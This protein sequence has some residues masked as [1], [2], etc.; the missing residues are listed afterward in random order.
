MARFRLHDVSCQCRDDLN[1]AYENRC[2]AAC[3]ETP[4]ALPMAAHPTLRARS[5]LTLFFTTSRTACDE[6]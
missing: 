5:V 6:H 1:V 2:Q 3:R 4:R